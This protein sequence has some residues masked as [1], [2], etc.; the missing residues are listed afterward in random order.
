MRIPQATT[1]GE[2]TKVAEAS[3]RTLQLNMA[4]AVDSID[5]KVGR[6]YAGRPNRMVVVG[7]DGNI[8]FASTPSPRGSDAA[9]L[10]DWL[11]ETLKR[12]PISTK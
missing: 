2:R 7:I 1:A 5:N 11:N 3:G 10:R 6:A 8:R 9:V 12:L 4:I